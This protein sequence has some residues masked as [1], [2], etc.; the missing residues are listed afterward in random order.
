MDDSVALRTAHALSGA[1]GGAGLGRGN[2][3]LRK[4]ASMRMQ[5]FY[6]TVSGMMRTQQAFEL[7]LRTQVPSLTEESLFALLKTKFTCVVAL[8]RYDVM[9]FDELGDV[10][11]LMAEFPLLTIAYIETV[12]EAASSRSSEPTVRYFSCL[13]DGSCPR[14]PGTRRRKPK[15]RI[16]L[17]GHP[18]LGNGKSDNQNLALIFTRG[19]VVQT[20]D[21]NQDGYIEEGFK[22]PCALKEFDVPVPGTDD[23]PAIVGFGEHI[24]SDLGS[25]GAFAA[26]A[27]QVFGGITQRTMTAPLRSRYHYGHPDMLDKLAMMAQ[28]GI[29]KATRTLNLSEDIYAGMDAQLRGREVKYREY[30]RVGKGRDMGFGSILGFISKLS[31]GTAQMST[32]RQSHRLGVR[33]GFG[34][35]LGFYYGH[36]GYYLSQLHFH[37]VLYITF[38]MTLLLGLAD[39]TGVL[40]NVAPAAI[41]MQQLIFS[42]FYIV[43]FFS[44]L[45]SHTM[46]LLT[47]EGPLSAVLEPC[48]Q[49]LTGSPLFFIAQSRCIGHFLSAEFAVG[50]AKYVATGRGIGIRRVPFHQIYAQFAA[51]CIYAGI[52]LTML[53]PGSL[54]SSPNLRPPIHA[55]VFAC[56]NP[57]S[58]VLAPFLFNPRCF[59]TLSCLRDMRSWMRWLISDADDG[60]RARHMGAAEARRSMS[61]HALLLPSKE[62]IIGLS[63]LLIAYEG[64][65]T[66]PMRWGVAHMLW[67]ALPILPAFAFAII[68]GV[69]AM[70]RG[71]NRLRIVN[72]CSYLAG[73]VVCAGLLAG[74]AIF[75]YYVYLD[76]AALRM[77]HETLW[78]ALIAARY[79]CWQAAFQTLTIIE[80]M[81]SGPSAHVIQLVVGGHCMLLDVI[82]GAFLQTLLLVA[83]L[84]PF[85]PSLHILFLFRT[86]KRGLRASTAKQLTAKAAG[87]R[88]GGTNPKRVSLISRLPRLSVFNAGS[89]SAIPGTI[90]VAE[91]SSQSSVRSRRSRSSTAGPAR[92]SVARRS[93]AQASRWQDEFADDVGALDELANLVRASRSSE[94]EPL[95]AEQSEMSTWIAEASEV[96]AQVGLVRK[97]PG[98][99]LGGAG[100]CALARA[101]GA[102][103][104]SGGASPGRV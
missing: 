65:S 46:Q 8:Q 82:I 56:V 98:G 85:S 31:R 39:G 73:A 60:W 99:V 50:G 59:A 35:L 51:P 87:T 66:E 14:L 12:A 61:L 1:G 81:L 88:G 80:G 7:L 86:H 94:A 57:F 38:V 90:D 67:I 93:A 24:F 19:T 63:A 62:L 29:S 100:A 32:S 45:L 96:G 23:G 102:A 75:V 101:R 52:E 44:N 91:L 17:P 16:E 15:Y 34:R 37:H 64:V 25:L 79:F 92:G 104:G 20:I 18:I 58:L 47:E 22:V 95:G 76:G 30:L 41:N 43:F 89:V 40:P 4:W 6:R 36:T 28:G 78:T 54:L 21:A 2:I 13:I 5:T 33:L 70:L 72:P 103:G 71:G 9:S 11:I 68:I 26:I 83:S 3:A 77:P 10:E 97:S 42:L 53:Y 69:V 74:E 48:R 84:V 49:L 27:E 55:L